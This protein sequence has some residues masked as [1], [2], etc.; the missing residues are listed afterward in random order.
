M[1]SNIS[2]KAILIN[3]PSSGK[4]LL[5]GSISDVHNYKNFLLSNR[6]GAWDEPQI[7]VLNN[8]SKQQ[9]LDLVH[10]TEVHYNS[11]YF[12]GHGGTTPMNERFIDLRDGFICDQQLKN[13]SHGQM[14][15]IDACGNYVS[16][17]ISGLIDF[18]PRFVNAS[19]RNEAKERFDYHIA[20]SLPGKIIVHGAQLGQ[21]AIDSANGGYFTQALLNIAVNMKSTENYC[22]VSIAEVIRYIPAYLK[23]R[24]NNQI[25]SIYSIG[26]LNVPFVFAFPKTLNEIKQRV[27]P[28]AYNK[29][30][31]SNAGWAFL[32]LAALTFIVANIK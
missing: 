17:S 3:A 16:P 31:N 25:P 18:G 2:R 28:P 8:P 6:G 10:S 26:N 1:S 32:S 27:S 14:I 30:N 13:F 19:G 15:T 23:A 24:K 9:V 29:V 21:P 20:N 5:P 22:P 4:R 7:K 12:S 11:I